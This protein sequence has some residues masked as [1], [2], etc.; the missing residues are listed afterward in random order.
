MDLNIYGWNSESGYNKLF[1]MNIQDSFEEDSIWATH[2]K[3]DD[4]NGKE[5]KATAE[6]D[7]LNEPKINSDF[8]FKFDDSYEN[9]DLMENSQEYPIK[10]FEQAPMDMESQELI[11]KKSQSFPSE[12]VQPIQEQPIEVNFVEEEEVAEMEIPEEFHPST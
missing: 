1:N 12:E 8:V 3:W 7:D 2:L 9:V 4:V 5:Q 6:D 11:L 10:C